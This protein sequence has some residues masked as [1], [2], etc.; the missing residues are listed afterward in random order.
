[1][2]S[3]C[4]RRGRGRGAVGKAKKIQ[5]LDLD[6]AGSGDDDFDPD[7]GIMAK[8]TKFVE[9]LQKHH[10]FCQ[11]CGPSKSC[12]ID[13]AANHVQLSNNQLR[14]WARSLVRTPHHSFPLTSVSD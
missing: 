2:L 11:L 3:L 4:A 8:E 6:H 13:Q 9:Q 1:M 7:L 10:G 12:K 14:G 5:I